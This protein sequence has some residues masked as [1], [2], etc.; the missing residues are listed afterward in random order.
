MVSSSRRV[1][2]TLCVL[3]AAPNVLQ[4]GEFE[5]SIARGRVT[6]TASE[7]PL[8]EVLAEWARIGD[9]QFI[10]ADQLTGRP[11][12]LQLVDVPEAD[13]LRI[14]LRSASGYLAAPRAA[15]LPGASVYDRVLIMATS[16]GP[17]NPSRPFGA[18]TAPDGSPVGAAAPGFSFVPGGNPT[19]MPRDPTLSV[20]PDE[21]A[22]LE[23]LQELLQQ[24]SVPGGAF[25]QPDF[26]PPPDFGTSPMPGQT[27][28]RP[29]MIV[30]APDEQQPARRGRPVR[31]QT[32]DP[33]TGFPPPR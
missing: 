26:A 11:V 20:T 16:R 31:P 25:G 10:D 6:L 22:Q 33:F 30:T 3:L 21:A 4:A 28:P 19:A 15:G 23:Q 24:P 17:T 27:T 9:T 13:A 5:L 12:T 2:A 32:G 8:G 29:G 7:V 1:I 18:A 14:L